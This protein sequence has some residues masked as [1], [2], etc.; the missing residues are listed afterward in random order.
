M[1]ILIVFQYLSANM[2]LFHQ[3]KK[4]K[5][6]VDCLIN[7]CSN[8]RVH[9]CFVQNHT[10]YLW[11]ELICKICK[12][13]DWK[14]YQ[15]SVY[16]LSKIVMVQINFSILRCV[17]SNFRLW[18]NFVFIFSLIYQIWHWNAE[19]QCLIW[20]SQLQALPTISAKFYFPNL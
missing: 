4:R 10:Q 7:R 11:W 13:L 16:N 12:F 6:Y 5:C 9:E 17:V 14:W 1:A 18:W 8:H 19:M 15:S 2:V 20:Q 3:Q